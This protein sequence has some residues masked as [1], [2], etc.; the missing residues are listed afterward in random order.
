M[1]PT[2]NLTRLFVVL[3]L[4]CACVPQAAPR[5]S[6]KTPT[7]AWESESGSQRLLFEHNRIV[8]AEGHDLKAVRVLESKPGALVVRNEGVKETWSVS[9]EGGRLKL[10]QGTATTVYHSLATTPPEL[11]LTPLTLGEPGS[12]TPKEIREISDQLLQRRDRDQAVRKDPKA[13]KEQWIAAND[14]NSAFLK[15]L[16]QRVGWIDAEHF[17]KPAS[18]AAVLLAKHTSDPRLMQAI[19]PKV[20]EDVKRSAISPELFSV[21]FDELRL[22][23]GEKQ[24]YGTQLLENQD[25][26]YVLPLEDVRKVD[27]F[28]KSI[29]LHPLAEYLETASK[30]LYD[31]KPIRLPREDE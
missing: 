28:R 23:L 19:L 9:A 22:S 8:V 24:R 13:T 6:S 10:G 17:G 15:S 27:D 26:P 3:L 30:Y 4:V 14:E 18:A 12:A 7:G 31:S 16:V 29:G 21:L 20:E 1:L 25:G 5:L 2:R 11:D